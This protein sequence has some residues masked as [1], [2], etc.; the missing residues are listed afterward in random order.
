LTIET[1]NI[2]RTSDPFKTEQKQE[3][4]QRHSPAGHL[5]VDGSLW[6]A[7]V[8]WWDRRLIPCKRQGR[9]LPGS[10]VSRVFQGLHA[11]FTLPICAILDRQ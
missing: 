5:Y 4:H 11:T 3:F 9:T 8:G 10:G 1:Q 6:G 7:L 2:V